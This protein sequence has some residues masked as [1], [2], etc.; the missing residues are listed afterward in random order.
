MGQHFKHTH[1]PTWR[2]VFPTL[3]LE[4][5]CGASEG[6]PLGAQG[7][8]QQLQGTA[9]VVVRPDRGPHLFG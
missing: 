1:A 7:S 5:D 9:R 8:L 4:A 6:A 3:V 2:G